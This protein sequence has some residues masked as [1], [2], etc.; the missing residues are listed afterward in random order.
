MS[1]LSLT[2][3]HAGRYDLLNTFTRSGENS[4]GL[5]M[6]KT[7][8][9]VLVPCVQNKVMFYL[10]PHPFTPL[11]AGTPLVAPPEPS[12][13]LFEAGVRTRVIEGLTVA[14]ANFTG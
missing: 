6:A 3:P 4:W 8:P 2:L 11:K 1:T 10:L 12:E 5:P 9:C 7:C 14:V 13:L